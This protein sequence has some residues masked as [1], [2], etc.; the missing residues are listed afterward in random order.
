MKKAR[1][2]FSQNEKKAILQPK[3][4]IFMDELLD[5]VNKSDKQYGIKLKH[6]DIWCDPRNYRE[7]IERKTE[8]NLAAIICS[9]NGLEVK[10]YFERH[11][12]L[13]DEKDS[14]KNRIYRN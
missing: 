11:Q 2:I 8:T 14:T 4:K 12:Y 3:N 13:I 1:R 10:D 6:P 9:I 5:A 7:V